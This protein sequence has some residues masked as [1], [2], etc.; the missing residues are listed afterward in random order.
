M[1]RTEEVNMRICIK[2]LCF[3]SQIKPRSFFGNWN[4]P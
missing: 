3:Y 4:I 2:I 1:S